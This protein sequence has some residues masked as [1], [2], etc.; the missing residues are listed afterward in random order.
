[1]KLWHHKSFRKCNMQ[2]ILAL[3]TSLEAKPSSVSG[4]TLIMLTKLC[5]GKVIL[6]Y[7]HYVPGF[8]QVYE[9]YK[10]VPATYCQRGLPCD[11]LASRPG[12]SSNT[13]RQHH[14]TENGI[15]SSH[16]GLWLVCAFT[17]FR[18]GVLLGILGGAVPPGSP[19]PD[20]ISHKLKCH[21]PHPF[22]TRLQFA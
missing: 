12:E 14:S 20:P 15:S 7:C 13:P 3:I 10:W 5:S 18:G 11:G 8:T 21:F 6:A 19:N 4:I 17:F 22:Q 2:N 1:M 16:L 9:E